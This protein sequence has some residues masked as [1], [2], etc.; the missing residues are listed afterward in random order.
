MKKT[1]LL[2]IALIFALIPSVFSQNH[3]I[4]YV[5]AFFGIEINFPK[6]AGYTVYTSESLKYD[7]AQPFNLQGILPPDSSIQLITA[8]HFSLTML[9]KELRLHDGT[10]LPT[11]D[12]GYQNY[13]AARQNATSGRYSNGA[14]IDFKGKKAFSFDVEKRLATYGMEVSLKTGEPFLT[15]KR[16]EQW[17]SNAGLGNGTYQVIY[18]SHQGRFFKILY[19]KDSKVA[20]QIIQNLTLT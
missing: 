19:R 20:Q 2:F 13:E 8:K 17:T 11:A 6:K 16:M 1:L 5:N 9:K 10:Y 14:Y 18:F 3:G 15:K 4:Q 12:Y 7:T